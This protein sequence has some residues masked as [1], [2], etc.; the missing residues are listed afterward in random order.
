MKKFLAILLM[1]VLVASAS[2]C[3]VFAAPSAEAQGVISGITATDDNQKEVGIS[4]QK[5]DGKVNTYFYNT[6]KGLRSETKNKTLKV[7]GHYDVTI[8][9]N[10][11]Y[12]LSVVLNVLG[13]SKSSEVYVLLQTGKEVIS[14]TPTVKNGKITF[15]LED[16]VD[17]IAIVTDSKT[18]MVIEKENNVLSPKTSDISFYFTIA[19]V[20]S[21]LTMVFVSKKIKA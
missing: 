15:E 7:V 3:S 8:E 2:I 21:A 20:V 4:L 9:G 11:E 5:I 12:P 10:P 1:A 14:V 16:E 19:I 17:K 13:I 6:L 18:A